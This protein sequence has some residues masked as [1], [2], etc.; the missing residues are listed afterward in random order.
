MTWVIAH[1]GSSD[2]AVENT[3]PAF[4]R[5]I[6]DGADFV[7]FDVQLSADG[8]PVVFHDAQL[9]RL[10]PL[11]GPLRRRSA[12][13]LQDAGIPT[14]DQVLEV[15]RGRIGVM[16]EL[17]NPHLY[18]AVPFVERV[19]LRL[20]PEDVVVS[21]QQRALLE[22]LRLAPRQRVIQHVGLGVSIRAAAGY[23]WGAGFRDSRVTGR[24]LARA[25]ELGLVTTVYTVNEEERMRELVALGVDGLFTDL[26]LRLRGV[27]RR[28][29]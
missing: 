10:T 15:V 1:R 29:G 21:F 14:L 24:G 11:Q 22:A 13:E 17:K 19:V 2:A 4:E 7:E 3:L 12:A 9:E 25:R 27:L 5:A 28:R 26:P 16:A 6:A 20:H 8:T 23:A 18:R